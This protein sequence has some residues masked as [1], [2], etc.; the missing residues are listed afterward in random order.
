MRALEAG[1]RSYTGGSL[2]FYLRTSGHEADGFGRGPYTACGPVPG[3][4]DDGARLA[5][6]QE[7]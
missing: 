2:F 6:R 1:E 7:S 3:Q 5:R 4:D